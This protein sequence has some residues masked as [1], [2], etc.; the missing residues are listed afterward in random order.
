MLTPTPTID[1]PRRDDGA[2]PPGAV[3]DARVP[4]PEPR[5]GP[6]IDWADEAAAAA[7]DADGR[8]GPAAQALLVTAARIVEDHLDDPGAALDH[9]DAALALGAGPVAGL[10]LRAV[11][12]LALEGGSVLG[13]LQ[14]LERELATNSSTPR[15]LEL[16]VEKGFLEADHLL[17][18]AAGRLTADEAMR[19]APGHRAALV[20]AQGLAER[21]GDTTWLRQILERRLAT[22]TSPAERARVLVRLAL[23]AE[24]DPDRAV[25]AASFF[26]QALDEDPRADAAPVARAGLRRTGA[27]LRRDVE[28]LRGFSAEAEALGAGPTRAGW[29]ATA[30][31]ISRHRLGAT[32]RATA[33]VDLG[34]ADEPSDFALLSTA[35]EDHLSAGRWARAVELLDRQADLATDQEYAAALEA[36]AASVA[37]QQL[38]DDAGAAQRLRRV[39][40][41]RPSDPVALAAMERIASRSGDVALQIE[42]ISSSVGRAEDPAE[43]A[44]LA[45]RVAELNEQ[46]LGDLDT[47]VSFAQRALDAIPGYGPAVHILDRLYQKLGRWGEMLRIIEADPANEAAATGS[48][49]VAEEIAAR[50]L[51]RLGE[52]YEAGLADPG[53]ALALYR[54]WADLGVRRSAALLALLRAAEKAGDAL[55]AAEAAMKLGLEIPELSEAQRIAWRYRAATLFEERAAADAEAVA[56]FESVLEL[57]PRFRPAFAGLARAYRRTQAWAPLADVLSRRAAC[58]PSASRSAALEVEAARVHAERLLSPSAAMAALDRAVAYDSGNLYALDYR[59]RLHMRQGRAEEAATTLGA[60]AERLADPAARAAMWRRQG[61]ILEWQL[62]R[63]REALVA[64]ERALASG[65]V[66]GGFA[67]ELAQ[68]RLLE[69]VGRPGDASA[70]RLERLGPV[71][72][73]ISE[74]LSGAVGRRVDL[75]VRLPDGE[76]ALRLLGQIAEVAPDNLFA[77]EIEVALAHRMGNDVVAA[78]ALERLGDVTR[79]SPSRVAWWRAAIGAH[80][81]GGVELASVYGLYQKIADADPAGDLLATVERLATRNRDW[82]RVVSARKA[83]VAL[84]SDERAR[85]VR[86]FAL[87]AAHLH[88]SDFKAA[89]ESLESACELAPDYIPARRLLAHLQERSGAARAAA[90][91]YTQVARGTHVPSRAV[92]AL[93]QAARLYLDSVR[94]PQAAAGALEELLAHDPDAEA[95]YQTIETILDQRGELERLIEVAR[96]RTTAG[97]LQSG[98]PLQAGQAGQPIEDRRD[99]LVHLAELL[100]RRRAADAIEPLQT[101]VALD[102]GHVPA[103]LH[104]AELFAE[105]GRPAEAVT[106]FRRV[107]AAAPD[108]RTVA[109]A[110]SRVGE[111]AAGALG[112]TAL[113]VAA[114]RSA[115]IASP[116]DVAALNGLTQGLLRRRELTAAAQTLRRLAA[117]DPDRE[118]RV[119]HWMSLGEILAGPARDLEGAAEAL[120]KA[121][122]IDPARPAIIERLHGV[123]VEIED[124]HRL[125]RALGRHLEA[126]PG[127]VEWRTQLA[128][129]WRGPL[130]SPERAADE[131]RILVAAQP[132]DAGLRADLAGALEDAGRTSDAIAEHLAIVAA[133]PLQLESFRALRRL[134]ERMGDRRRSFLAASVLVAMGVAEPEVQRRA[135]EAR[136]RWVD[137]PRGRV[138]ATVWD[139]IVRHPAE[140]H[141]VTAL[142]ASL[143]EV[144]PRLHPFAVE[145]WGVSRADRIGTRSDEPIRGLVQRM[146]EVFGLEEPYEIYLARTGVPQIEIEATFPPSLIVP[147]TLVGTVPRQELF[148]QV[149]RQLGR[150]RSGTYAATRLSARDLGAV[151]AAAMRTRFVDYG[152]GLAPEEVLSD[153]AQK[154]GRLVPRRHRRSFERAV[155]GVAEAGPLDVERWRQGMVH[156]AHRASLVASGDLL[157]SLEFIIRS[158]RRLAA[159]STSPAELVEAA[160]ATPEVVELISFAFSD[161]Y[162]SLASRLASPATS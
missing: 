78:S 33:T 27:R 139:R 16:L 114:Y 90:E 129:L 87:A 65:R 92:A 25:E 99:R 133:Q 86:L 64:V 161:D 150:L 125:A 51:E 4:A 112:D 109:A 149:G 59:W 21:A 124:P 5:G 143:I 3:A 72:G 75:A 117:V 151:L 55:V 134:F 113:T 50:R 98:Q 76:E 66:P 135:R 44:A 81:R 121:L 70:L 110:W 48:V 147:A 1:P 40:A 123:L 108:A 42:L 67:I 155:L 46:G 130:G 36:L 20:L 80:A 47:A 37:E 13:A 56:A 71:S 10:A 126:N 11:R 131:L 15:R 89:T 2:R 84:A 34:L 58:E 158:D 100:R 146:A 105:L 144:V 7:E 26:G 138:E 137:E 29:L 23:S 127:S 85:A 102:P 38:A 53:K 30:A 74:A 96:R 17:L 91:A 73:R 128:A 122:E 18:P 6:A 32:E 63:P 60:L 162:A 157:G 116:D 136:Y 22:A 54:E 95:D 119:R 69:L 31:A 12:E 9:L 156:T 24:A 101:A 140:R 97:T 88:I 104:L 79:D 82:A 132:A 159:A 118:A 19:L 45:V 153:F 41:V 120:E 62:G 49:G 141:P 152:R 145:D 160:R 68:E 115:L 35:A 52:V 111:I 154:I 28:L 43:R 77:L 106:T 83:L 61:E 103:L 57:A 94:D 148:L 39:L 14:A 142:L 107:V 8:E 93:R